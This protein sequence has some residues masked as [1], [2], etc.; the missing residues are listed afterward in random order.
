MEKAILSVEGM[1]CNHCVM[2]VTKALNT[3]LGIE[4]VVVDL[5]TETVTVVYNPSITDLVKIKNE[6]EEVGYDVHI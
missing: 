4:S 2:T 6:I 5:D 3:M 1:T